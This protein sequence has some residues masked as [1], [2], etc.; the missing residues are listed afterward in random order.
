MRE[1]LSLW[2]SRERAR[3]R[4]LAAVDEAES[5]LERGEGR[6]LTPQEIPDFVEQIHQRGIARHDATR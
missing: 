2:E 4:I 1:A 5:S 6:T 3:A